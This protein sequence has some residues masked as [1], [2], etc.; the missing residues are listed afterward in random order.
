MR[1]IFDHTHGGVHGIR[2]RCLRAGYGVHARGQALQHVEQLLRVG[3]P[4]RK[5]ANEIHKL[6]APDVFLGF[7]AILRATQRS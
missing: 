1:V 3:N 2:V 7:F 4:T 6:A 5:L